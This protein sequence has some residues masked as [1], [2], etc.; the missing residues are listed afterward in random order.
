MRKLVV[1]A[2]LVALGSGVV[3]G[4]SVL[5]SSQAAPREVSLNEANDVLGGIGFGSCRLWSCYPRSC[6]IWQQ[7]VY[8]LTAD[9]Y[10]SCGTGVSGC[11]YELTQHTCVF[12]YY[13]DSLCEYPTGGSGTKLADYCIP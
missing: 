6:H 3:G 12:Q 9:T 8:A 1:V 2:T 11:E 7:G 10:K 5:A 4:R 13:S